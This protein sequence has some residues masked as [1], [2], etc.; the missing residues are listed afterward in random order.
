MPKPPADISIATTAG[1]D[2][3]LLL[4]LADIEL[5]GGDLVGRDEVLQKLLALDSRRRDEVVALGWTLCES[6]HDAAFVCI[7]A[8]V[9]AAIASAEFETGRGLAA[10]RS[11]NASRRISRRC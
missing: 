11:S 3:A 9:D 5:R 10:G 6:S 8:A 4:A 7:D 2:P 1:D